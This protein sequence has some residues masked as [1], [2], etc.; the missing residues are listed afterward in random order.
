MPGPRQ[1]RDPRGPGRSEPWRRSRDPRGPGRRRRPRDPRGQGR[2]E[3][4]RPRDPRGP[5]RSEPGLPGRPR[6][7]RGQ[8]RSEPGFCELR[9]PGRSEPGS[10]K[11]VPGVKA[12]AEQTRNRRQPVHLYS[13]SSLVVKDQ[14]HLQR[15]RRTST[16]Q[17]PWWRFVIPQRWVA[18][19]T[20]FPLTA[21]IC[22]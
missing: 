21:R 10:Q 3:P 19:G 8:G 16:S 6:D 5:G 14:D 2:S 11:P 4:G 20:H 15:S 18:C 13:L 1:P 17:T 12:T 7:P 9:G 22:W